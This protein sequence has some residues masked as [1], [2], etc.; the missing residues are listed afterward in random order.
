MLYLLYGF[1]VEDE[2]THLLETVLLGKV[3]FR[4]SQYTLVNKY[5]NKNMVDDYESIL[6]NINLLYISKAIQQPNSLNYSVFQRCYSPGS[7]TNS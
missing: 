7:T 4:Y 5:I 2:G 1:H 3:A 6:G